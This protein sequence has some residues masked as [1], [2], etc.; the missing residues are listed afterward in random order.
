MPLRYTIDPERELILTT[1]EGVLTDKDV[2][3]LKARILADPLYRNE[4]RE[5]SDVRGV[6]ELHVTP[7]GIAAF[8]G[9]DREHA[10]KTQ[11]RR[12]ALVASKDLVF[13]MARMYEGLSPEESPVGVFRSMD[14]AKEW[15]GVD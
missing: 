14:E 13:G 8:T 3:D 9:F 2:L 12:L 1:G 10:D 7:Q 6:T 11:G 5:L 15:L 4:L